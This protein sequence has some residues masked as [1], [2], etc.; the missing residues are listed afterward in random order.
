MSYVSENRSAMLLKWWTQWYWPGGMSFS[1]AIRTMLLLAER[2]YSETQKRQQFWSNIKHTHNSIP[3]WNGHKTR[4]QKFNDIFW[5]CT[6]LFTK[7]A[8]QFKLHSHTNIKIKIILC[9][10]TS[11][12]ASWHPIP[13]HTKKHQQI[14]TNGWKLLNFSLT[15]SFPNYLS[16]YAI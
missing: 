14:Q 10:C 8:L 3:R 13:S 1:H 2:G 11:N 6:W 7:A 4:A 12:C 15:N 9:Q 16:I 5:I